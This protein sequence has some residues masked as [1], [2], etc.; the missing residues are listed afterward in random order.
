MTKS[1]LV[2]K[3]EWDDVL[4]VRK[5]L[6][7]LPWELSHVIF[8]EGERNRHVPDLQDG[9]DEFDD[10]LECAL[11]GPRIEEIKREMKQ[12]DRFPAHPTWGIC[13]NHHGNHV[14]ERI[15]A[16]F[17]RKKYDVPFRGDYWG[18]ASSRYGTIPASQVDSFVP[19]TEE[20]IKELGLEA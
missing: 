2:I 6:I 17:A 7:P 1:I 13:L 8:H 20:Q 10:L 11:H 14:P 19:L 15:L 9:Y 16:K 18:L 4:A 5:S 3:G 12:K